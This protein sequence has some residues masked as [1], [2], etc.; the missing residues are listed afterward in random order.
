MAMWGTDETDLTYQKWTKMLEEEFDRQ[1]IDAEI[2]DYY[3]HIGLTYEGMERQRI[4]EFV[5]DLNAEGKCPDL[6]VGC[7][8]FVRWQL[9]RNLDSL[10][11]S[12]PA[13][14]F[15]QKNHELLKMMK[16]DL[17]SVEGQIRKHMVQIHDTIELK[18]SLDFI[19]FLEGFRPVSTE[20]SVGGRSH[21]YVGLLDKTVWIDSL[22]WLDLL[23]QINRLNPEE[24]IS[25]MEHSAD[26]KFLIK[27]N[28]E[29]VKQFFTT[30]YKT[31]ASNVILSYQP[32]VWQYYRTKSQLRFIQIKHDEV[33]RSLS[34]GPPIDPYYT[35]TAEDFLVNDSCIGGHFSSVET[36]MADA[37][38][39]GKRL[40]KGES[41]ESIG[42]LLHTTGYHV[43]WNLMRP[44]RAKLSDM[45]EYVQIYNDTLYDRDPKMAII[46][47]SVLI[48]LSAVLI[49]LS[50]IYSV[51]S[52]IKQRR[53]RMLVKEQMK[54]QIYNERLL[55]LAINTCG[56]KMWDDRRG[57][58]IIDRARVNDDWK[59][60]L[61]GFYNATEVGLHKTEF[62]GRID[63]D[64]EDHW[65]FVRMDVRNEHGKV[66]RS[67]YIINSDHVKEMEEK[68]REAHEVMVEARAREG[69]LSSMNHEIR[70][71]LHAIVGFTME[72]ARPEVRFSKEEIDMFA[73][74]IDGNAASL[75]KII[76]DILLV[77]L[78]K[79]ANVSAH[80]TECSI[81]SLLDSRLWQEAMS[82]TQRRHNKV[83]IA[84]G[85]D[86][87][88]VNADP[89]M[90]ATV[91][92]N[93]IINASMFSAE[94]STITIGWETTAE[95]PEI[96]VQDQGIGIDPRHHK[97]IFERFTKIN[98]FSPGCGLGLFI[99]KIYMDKMNGGISVESKL[100]E[101]ARFI[102]KFY[103]PQAVRERHF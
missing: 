60:V 102:L 78:M 31:P 30:S 55:E 3:G 54:Q 41:A 47:Y 22:I 88:M 37:V 49:V 20:P 94:G 35:I 7:G 76:N 80:C 50:V 87:V 18:N 72:L 1:G 16:E 6:I 83:T 11:N 91:I 12:I 65:Y 64:T 66:R 98:S 89:Q 46:V 5:H 82:L 27:K 32:L 79:N 71:P 57:N 42:R 58:S 81:G 34:E 63:D 9:Q 97:M 90:V 40:L 69:F 26:D 59:K 73:D 29:G 13:V 17:E 10:V 92:E 2:H 74:I 67:G 51:H 84:R 100:G 52:I 28:N 43:N 21:R 33:S 75:K 36:M 93:L 15:A 96:W 99:C 61:E 23:D 56:S 62:H 101:G 86:D 14:C 38:S 53:S 39:A 70:T 4:A 19:D 45:P 77:T 48:V 103:P 95:G 85:G 25:L 68:A 24:Y 44:T 8:D